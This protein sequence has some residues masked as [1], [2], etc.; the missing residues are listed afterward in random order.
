MHDPHR[1]AGARDRRN[2]GR[3]LHPHC[4]VE[5][6]SVRPKGREQPGREHR[7]RACTGAQRAGG[8]IRWYYF[9]FGLRPPFPPG[10]AGS[11]AVIW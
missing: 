6:C 4:R 2:P 3:V 8:K 9:K 5:A 11:F 7:A 10:E 1:G